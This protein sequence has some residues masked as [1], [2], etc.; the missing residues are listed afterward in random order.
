MKAALQVNSDRCVELLGK[1]RKEMSL[2]KKY[3]NELVELR[4]NIRV[5]CRVR[6]P[7]KEDGHG[8]SANTVVTYDAED[9]QLI[10]VLFKGRT[11][12]FNMDKVFQS[13]ISQE[14]VSE[15]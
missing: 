13:D 15:T 14:Q 6:P 12:T 11:Q 3:H 1:Y 4:G 10:N 9:D 8:S 7:I 2:R 5:Y